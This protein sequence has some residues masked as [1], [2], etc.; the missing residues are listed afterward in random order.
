MNEPDSSFDVHVSIEEDVTSKS[1]KNQT[2]SIQEKFGDCSADPATSAQIPD[3]SEISYSQ[4]QNIV[5]GSNNANQ[6]IS[7]SAIVVTISVDT[8][9][10]G[11]DSEIDQE[12]IPGMSCLNLPSII[13]WGI[14]RI[15]NLQCLTPRILHL[16]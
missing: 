7:S 10:N 4:A 12:S 16:L 8:T 13:I 6:Q 9:N 3:I 14:L 5:G 11:N 15:T 2:V 1:F